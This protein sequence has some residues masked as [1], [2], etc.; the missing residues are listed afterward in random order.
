MMHEYFTHDAYD[1]NFKCHRAREWGGY[2][3]KVWCAKITFKSGLRWS[4]KSVTIISMYSHLSTVNDSRISVDK[5]LIIRKLIPHKIH[6]PS[7]WFHLRHPTRNKS[8]VETSGR[9]RTFRRAALQILITSLTPRDGLS[10]FYPH[11]SWMRLDHA[12]R[13]VSSNI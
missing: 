4:L 6:R 13:S 12:T 2:I 3:Y 8:S 1:E 9:S 7:L 10:V 5:N 11:D